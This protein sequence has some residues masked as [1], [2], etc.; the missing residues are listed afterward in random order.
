M[1]PPMKTSVSTGAM[2]AA[3]RPPMAPPMTA[4]GS[5][6]LAWAASRSTAAAWSPG[7][8]VLAASRRGTSVARRR[9]ETMRT[10]R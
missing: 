9:L 4:P 1:T 10:L 3:T 6:P 2:P 5:P 8:L 7:W